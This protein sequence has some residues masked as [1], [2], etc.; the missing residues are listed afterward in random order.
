MTE[1]TNHDRVVARLQKAKTMGFK[2]R[3]IAE[4]AEMTEYR[5]SSVAASVEERNPYKY[6]SKL[7]D[8]ECERITRALDMIKAAL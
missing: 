7:T 1:Q 3:P 8:E 5:I 4:L 2:M 6:A